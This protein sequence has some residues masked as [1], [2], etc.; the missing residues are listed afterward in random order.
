MEGSPLSLYPPLRPGGSCSESCF[1]TM[2]LSL[3][4]KL[5]LN[6]FLSPQILLAALTAQGNTHCH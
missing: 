3:P 2:Y 5:L 1:Q 4:A 6:P